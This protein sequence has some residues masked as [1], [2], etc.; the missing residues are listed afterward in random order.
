LYVS[1]NIG[2]DPATGNL[3]PGGVENEAVQGSIKIYFLSNFFQLFN[4]PALQ[5]MGFILSEAGLDYDS[6]V[7]TD[8]LLANISD[9]TSV[10]QI[11]EK[12]FKTH[13]PARVTYQ[14]AA[15]P[16]GAQIEIDAIAV[17]GDII[18]V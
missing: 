18:D 13:Y 9:F 7:K 15:L 17:I 3:V 10:N 11:Y 2:I 6:V 12:F 8:I 4:L 1:G 16:K 5:N 14:V